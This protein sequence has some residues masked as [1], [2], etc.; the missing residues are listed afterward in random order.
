VAHR[1]RARPGVFQL[2]GRTLPSSFTAS[3]VSDLI[4]D[5]NAAN[6]QGGSNTITLAAKAKFTLKD[7]NNTTDGPTGLPVIAANEN[8]TIAG[9]G[10]VIGRGSGAPAFRLFDVA[11]AA[12]LTLE[13]LTVQ[14]GQAAEGGAI[15]NQGTLSLSGVTVQNNLAQGPN[16]ADATH[17]SGSSPGQPAAGGGI[18][19]IGSLSLVNGTLIQNNQCVAGSGGNGGYGYTGQFGGNA[20]G[21]GLYAG[22][23]IA[24]TNTTLS[25]NTVQGGG[26]GSFGGNGGSAFGGGAEYGGTLTLSNETV[27]GNQAIGGQEGASSYSSASPGTGNGGGLFLDGGSMSITNVTAESNSA[28]GGAGYYAGAAY[29]GGVCLGTVSVPFVV[30]F[31]NVAMQNNT[32]KDGAGSIG[33]LISFGGGIYIDP[34]ATVYMDSSTVA[35]TINNT[36]DSGLNGTTANIDGAYT[37]QSC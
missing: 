8:L 25:N 27:T 6:A 17:K 4:N 12:S 37:L 5:I 24:I 29:G 11:G 7:V 22:G 19:S 9:N 36:D 23:S 3:T 16:G 15:Y 10:D 30:T 28:Q 14:N 21:G 13:N 31:C 33:G 2:E 34:T 20:W 35:N 32:A 18:F 1:R 26:G